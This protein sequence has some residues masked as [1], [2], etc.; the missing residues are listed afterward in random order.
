MYLLAHVILTRGVP[1]SYVHFI[2]ENLKRRALKQFSQEH[3]AGESQTLNLNPD[4][5]DSKIYAFN[6]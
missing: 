6:H 4:P 2:D 5:S 3:K 1:A